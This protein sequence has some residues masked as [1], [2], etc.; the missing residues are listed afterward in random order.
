MKGHIL[1]SY[2]E[3]IHSGIYSEVYKRSINFITMPKLSGLGQE[4]CIIY[5]ELVGEFVLFFGLGQ[6]SQG[7]DGLGGA[8]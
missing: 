6:F 7:K 3:G 4:Y 2:L 1:L 5:H 8:S